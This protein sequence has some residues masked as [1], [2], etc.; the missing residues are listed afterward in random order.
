LSSLAALAGALCIGGADFLGG[1]SSRR[2]HP[3][4]ATFAINLVALVIFVVA[5]AVVQ[6]H[7]GTGNALGALA[8]GIVS[9]IGLNLIYASFAAGAMSL[10]APL[11]ACGSALVPTATATVIGEPP[12]SLQA[13]GILF[14]LV[15]VVAITWTPPGSPDHVPL[16][17]RAL[18]L[19][20]VASLVGGASFSI[21]LLSVEGGGGET[22]LGVAAISRLASTGACLVIV[23]TLIGRSQRGK[24]PTAPVLGAGVLEAAGTTFFLVASTLGNAAVVA[25]IVSLY[26]IVT[27]LLAQT[28]LRERIATHQG[29]G[30]AAAA[31]G[32]ALLSAA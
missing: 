7:L 11:I 12:N 25:V 28:V 18:A 1:L 24:P 26:A 15:G 21:L 4:V 8:G 3:V 13:V 14:A 6:P 22:A 17:R 32:V 23:F 5:F 19:T 9:A 29:I 30:I 31:V 20:T 27:V 10:T 16:S 2:S